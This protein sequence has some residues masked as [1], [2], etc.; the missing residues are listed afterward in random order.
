MSNNTEGLELNF[1]YFLRFPVII[2]YNS[3][4]LENVYVISFIFMIRIGSFANVVT[5][6]SIYSVNN[7]FNQILQNPYS[8]SQLA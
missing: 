3:L 7:I 5:H 6:S 4:L 1:L 2:N 8:N